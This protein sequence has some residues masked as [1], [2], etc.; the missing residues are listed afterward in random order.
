MQCL[1]KLSGQVWGI[2][3][4]FS[5]KYTLR[6]Y[7]VS[8]NI[9]QCPQ[10]GGQ[11]MTKL[12]RVCSRQFLY[13]CPPARLPYTFLSLSHKFSNQRQDIHADRLCYLY[14]SKETAI[15][16]RNTTVNPRRPLIDSIFSNQWC[17]FPDVIDPLLAINSYF[18]G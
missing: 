13:S 8:G 11:G 2:L 4:I 9:R 1:T 12:K 18:L 16:L 7:Q 15:Q 6:I 10:E 17:Q 5:C 14:V 3:C